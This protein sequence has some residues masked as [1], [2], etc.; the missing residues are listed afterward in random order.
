MLPSVLLSWKHQAID[1]IQMKMSEANIEDRQE[2]GRG[3][4]E[5]LFS[6]G[7]DLDVKRNTNV[8]LTPHIPALKG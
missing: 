8:Q 1:V 7:T 5:V 2:R 6:D 3:G 4:R